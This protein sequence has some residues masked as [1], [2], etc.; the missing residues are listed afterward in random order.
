[1]RLLILEA[2][3]LF[4][5]RQPRRTSLLSLPVLQIQFRMAI[6]GAAR[7]RAELIFS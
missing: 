7:R 5:R 6:E 4:L 3:I 1:M 2:E